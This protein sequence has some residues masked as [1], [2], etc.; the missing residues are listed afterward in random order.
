MQAPLLPRQS[1]LDYN[2]AD[3]DL[4]ALKHNYKT[5]SAFAGQRPVMGVVKGDA[6]GH[7]LVECAQALVD[8]GAPVLGVLD[9]REGAA[10]RAAGIKKTAIYVLAG[11]TSDLQ[12]T[13]A[14]RND[15]SAFV[16]S[17]EQL[18]SLATAAA[19]ETRRLRC[20][21]KIDTGMGRLGVPWNQVEDFLAMAAGN[22]HLDVDG[23]A[24]H[25]AT[26]GDAP[27]INQLTRFWGVCARAEQVFRRPLVHS[28]LSGGAML[29]HPDYPDGLS[30]PG[31][32]LYGAVPELSAGPP[33]P[34]LS[35][36][37]TPHIPAPPPPLGPTVRALPPASRACADNLR[38]VMRVVT[39]VLQV[40]TVRRG[41]AISYE[42]T[43][44]AE[45]DIRA[46]ILPIGYVHGLQILR[47]GKC[48]A[49]IRGK[50]APQLG[51]VCMNLSVYDANGIPSVQA[52]DEAVLLGTQ[53][54]I[55]LGP[56]GIPGD[57]LSPYETLCLFGRLNAR[58]FTKR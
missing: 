23:L 53:D 13:T 56:A 25:L 9:A 57:G 36:A 34:R 44:R 58:R 8:A 18:L 26:I 49:I 1:T 14:M 41:E 39:R 20:F 15:L 11:L 40:K 16:Y 19:K 50:V 28:A 17:P 47:S 2:H 37:W 31:L 52:G 7:G 46:V 30:R 45:R 6:Y 12:M 54:G 24:T 42:G 29:A 55:T 22:P 51:R 10:L 4:D 38:P 3:I 27:A 35:R 43:Y 33:P 21:L 48:A 32:V 5:I